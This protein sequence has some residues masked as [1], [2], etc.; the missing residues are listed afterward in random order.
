MEDL[1]VNN[2]QG[3]IGAIIIDCTD[4]ALDEN[5]IAAELFNPRFYRNIYE[6]LED[7]GVFSQQITKIFYKEAFSERVRTGGFNHLD[8][9]MSSTPEYGG[10]LPLA[11]VKKC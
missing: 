3:K 8:F 2:N 11:I 5:S 4:F 6:L 1:L 9:I 10:E 7:G